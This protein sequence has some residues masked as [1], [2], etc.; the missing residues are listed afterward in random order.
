MEK[1]ELRN[2]LHMIEDCFSNSISVKKQSFEKDSIAYI[3][4][5]DEPHFNVFLQRHPHQDLNQ[6]LGN[7][8]SFFAQHHVPRWVYVVP[9]DLDT[10]SLQESLAQHD[11]VFS[12]KSSVMHY[13]FG[14]S[15]IAPENSLTIQPADTNWN[16]FLQSMLEAF[17]GTNETINQYDQA[18]KRAASQTT[19]MQHFIGTL[20]GKPITTLTLTFLNDW[21]RIDNVA[22]IP[23]H[24]RLGYAT[25]IMQFGMRLA[26]Q[27]SIKHCVL[28]ASSKGLNVYKRL[29]FHELFTYHIYQFG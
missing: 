17:G 22:T 7:I 1:F 21:V 6:L 20:N 15:L 25:Q 16:G 2:H 26:Q 3:A 19:N 4:N 14:S 8:K 29:G 28:D 9:N 5:I 24:Q 13:E 27:K 23:S 12:E 11:I 10:P 18:L